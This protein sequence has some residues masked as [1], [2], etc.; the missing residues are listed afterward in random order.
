V[1]H[2]VHNAI[3]LGLL[4]LSQWPLAWLPGWLWTGG[5]LLCAAGAIL[6]LLMSG[7]RLLVYGVK[8]HEES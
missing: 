6:Y 4:A 7:F 8:I 1:F 5:V 2:I 3:L